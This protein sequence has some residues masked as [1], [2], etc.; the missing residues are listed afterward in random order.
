M[1]AG[2]SSLFAC[3]RDVLR[4]SEHAAYNRIEVARAARRLPVVLQML[5]EGSVNLTTAR[6]LAPH[7]T[8]DNHRAVLDSARGKRKGEVEAIV[9]GLAPRPD[10]PPSLRKLPAP[11]STLGPPSWRLDMPGAASAAE[12]TGAPGAAS[13]APADA[14]GAGPFAAPPGASVSSR[15]A[16]AA[17]PATLTPLSPDRH[18]LQLT[19]G[20]AAVWGIVAGRP[21]AEGRPLRGTPDS[22]RNELPGWTVARELR[23]LPLLRPAL[24]P[25]GGRSE[26]GRPGQGSWGSGRDPRLWDLLLGARGVETPGS[27]GEGAPGSIVYAAD[28]RG[29][30]LTTSPRPRPSVGSRCGRGRRGDRRGGS[31]RRRCAGPHL[32]RGRLRERG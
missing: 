4:L 27:T 20:A 13:G 15:A 32:P 8:P 21:L 30:A 26:R 12:A 11:Q 19:S 3:C 2:Y 18:K 10:V 24:R 17:P 25:G 22:F 29:V 6:L 14:A 5:E 9:A 7:L 16:G 31:G 28:L 1:R 23:G